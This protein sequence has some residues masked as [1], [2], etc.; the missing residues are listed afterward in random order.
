MNPHAIAKAVA[1][2][3]AGFLWLVASGISI[4]AQEISWRFEDRDGD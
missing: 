3:I 2:S 4:A 1:T